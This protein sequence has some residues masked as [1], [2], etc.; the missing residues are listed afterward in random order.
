MFDRYAVYAVHLRLFR[1]S[2]QR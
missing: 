2:P 1:S